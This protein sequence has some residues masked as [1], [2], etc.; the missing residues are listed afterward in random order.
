[1]TRLDRRTL[2]Q[3]SGAAAIGIS[4]LP[5]AACAGEGAANGALNFYTWDTYIGETTL[6]DF[7]NEAG[8]A[9]KTSYYANNDELFAKL[10]AGNPG[11]DVIVPSDEF[12]ERMIL[13]DM[14]APLDKAKLP[15][16]KN[17]DPQF[18]NASYDPGDRF[19][20]P[21]TWLVLGIGYRKSKVDGVPDSWKWIYDSDRYKGRIAM[22][23]EAADM[24]RLGGK[25]LGRPLNGMTDAD[26]AEVE[27]MLVKQKPNFKMFHEDNGQD[28]LAAGDVDLALEYNGDI[29][30]VMLEDPDLGFV[31]PKE[32]S[33]MNVDC[34]AIPKGAPNLDNAH[35]FIDFLIS[36]E[37][38][39]HIAETIQYPTPNAAA[40]AL[41]PP[42]YRDNPVIFPTPDTLATSEF[43]KFPGPERARAY[44]EA[45]TRVRAA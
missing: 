9:V 3:R 25:Y 10:R 28:L 15:N 21:Y 22:V 16:L 34:L 14:L 26:L 23:G 36:A 44:E 18:R 27:R 19:S 8:I 17:I 13:A 12:V 37:A 24:M 20:V 7:Q 33:M 41:M 32:G 6:A 1:M 30:Q 42:T 5:L 31:V 39:K 29:A 11:Y 45:A 4:F 35:K 38:G 43:G 40:K 2:L